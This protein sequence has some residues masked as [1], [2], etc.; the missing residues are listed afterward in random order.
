[1]SEISPKIRKLLGPAAVDATLCADARD[2]VSLQEIWRANSEG[3]REPADEIDLLFSYEEKHADGRVFVRGF[4]LESLAKMID[5]QTGERNVVRHPVSGLP[6]P[7]EALERAQALI[8][9]QGISGERVDFG[10]LNIN[11]LT[12]DNMRFFALEI[13][14]LLATIDVRVDERIFMSLSAE[15]LTRLALETREMLEANLPVF[16]LDSL[17]ATSN[18]PN[19]SR[20]TFSP[21]P[22][23]PST[24]ALRQFVLREMR[25]IFLKTQSLVREISAP[26]HLHLL[27]YVFVGALATVCP[28]VRRSFQDSLSFSFE[29]RDDNREHL[30]HSHEDEDEDDDS[31]DESSS[32]ED[33]PPVSSNVADAPPPRSPSS[34][35]AL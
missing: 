2:P 1:M 18:S 20:R 30:D 27:G 11:E 4:A 17:N 9:Q 23:I 12:D 6:L 24:N 29:F 3:A 33:E 21:L 16:V 26:G 7:N 32:D 35:S 10:A 15:R 8:Q 31:D 19:A 5:R 14:Q 22:K 25:R 13:F 34:S 28:E